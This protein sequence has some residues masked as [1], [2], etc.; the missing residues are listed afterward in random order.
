MMT[1]R[2][3]H[4]LSQ[5]LLLS[6][7]AFLPGCK[8]P[9]GGSQQE[10]GC[11]SCGH[12]A[13]VV[14]EEIAFPGIEPG[15][16]EETVVSFEG[17]PAAVGRDY[18]KNIQMIM[19]AQPAL[20]DM[21]P[22]IPEEQQKEMFSQIL[23][24]MALEKVMLR[25]IKDEGIDQTTEFR[26]NAIRVHEAVDRD[27]A[28][29][30]FENELLKEVIVTDDEIRK[31]YDENR[32]T[33]PVFQRPPFLITAGGVK[34][35][36]FEAADEKEAQELAEKVKQ[37]KFAQ[38]AKE[39]KKSVVDYGLVNQQSSLDKELKN[40][41]VGATGATTEVVKGADGKYHVLSIATPQET[42]YADVDQVKDS[43]KQVITGKKF[44]ELHSKRMD[45]LKKKYKVEVNKDYLQKRKKAT[46]QTMPA[47]E[48]P[49]EATALAGAVSKAQQAA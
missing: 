23:D 38:V 16:L 7:V 48:V 25:Y 34:A 49:E 41:I 15:L 12:S 10:A 33:E 21:L 18:E 9:F 45:E 26:K 20:K 22:Y 43:I 30:A 28:L 29:R 13:A 44:N 24:A 36:G 5:M 32:T 40:K 27:L 11:A 2:S 37:G 19:E 39:A 35:K 8:L 31:Y 14:E 42:K 1:Q 47:V 17:K 4:F 3:R 46:E 6:A